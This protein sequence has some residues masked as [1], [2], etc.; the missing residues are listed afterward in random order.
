VF[1]YKD[2]E[3]E[4]G[5]KKHLKKLRQPSFDKITISCQIF[6]ETLEFERNLFTNDPFTLFTSLTQL[7]EKP[8]SAHLAAIDCKGT[9][10]FAVL[11]INPEAA[12]EVSSG[13]I[14]Q[15]AAKARINQLA[16]K[17]EESVLDEV[18]EL[19]KTYR[20]LSSQTGFVAP[21]ESPMIE[22]LCADVASM[23]AY[24]EENKEDSDKEEN[25]EEDAEE[26][27]L[28]AEGK[29]HPTKPRLRVR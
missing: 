15:L 7:P 24:Q 27:D 12:S 13:I 3:V 4:E 9:T 28:E 5:V 6:P 23:F 18:I 22:L 19:G 29:Q 1:I 11:E 10:H 21:E 17:K 14:H 25:S 2:T 16:K 8:V 26:Q 20:L